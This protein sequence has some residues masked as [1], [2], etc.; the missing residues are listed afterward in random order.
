MNTSRSLLRP[1]LIFSFIALFSNAN[2]SKWYVNSSTG[3]NTN[4]GK[5]ATATPPNIGPFKEVQWAI[6]MAL[7][8]DSIFVAA[9]NYAE[10]LNIDKSVSIFGNNAGK[11]GIST[12]SAESVL[13]PSMIDLTPGNSSVQNCVVYITMASVVLD[14]F[15]IDGNNPSLSSGNNV[16]GKD[17]DI[18]NG[19]G[20]AG[21]FNSIYIQNNIIQNLNQN[22]VVLSGSVN[23]PN[24]NC[25][26]RFNF[27]KN[28]GTNS[29]GVKL[30]HGFFSDVVSNR[31]QETDI[32]VYITDFKLT[33]NKTWT[34][35]NNLLMGD[36]IGLMVDNCRQN[37]PTLLIQNNNFTT[38][39]S[40]V[41]D[42]GVYMINNKLG[43]KFSSLNNKFSNSARGY[44]LDNTDV[45][46]MNFSKDSFSKVDYGVS[47]LN[48]SDRKRTDS[49]NFSQCDFTDCNAFGVDVFSDSNRAVVKLSSCNFL[50]CVGGVM[51]RG[52]CHLIPGAAVFNSITDYYIM[53]DDG[54]ADIYSTDPIDATACIM[55]GST[56]TASTD[57]ENFINEDKIRHFLDEQRYPFVLFK[58]KYLYITNNDGNIFVQ[59][60][61]SK[62]S[63]DWHI[64]IDSVDHQQDVYIFNQT[65]FHTRGKV[66]IGSINMQAA[67]KSLFLHGP[68][69]MSNTLSLKAGFL[70]TTNGVATVGQPNIAKPL[71]DVS[72]GSPLSYVEGP[73]RIVMDGTS[74]DSAFFPV[75]KSGDFRPLAIMT[76]VSS[77]KKIGTVEAELFQGAAPSQNPAQGITHTSLVHHWK[78]NNIDGIPF[79]LVRFAGTY[80]TV[81]NDDEVSSPTQLK[82]VVAE[83]GSWNSIG[84]S[85]NAPSTGYIISTGPNQSMSYVSL[86]NA[87]H[88]SNKLG[89]T[90]AIAAF[91]ISNPCYPAAVQFTDIST[92]TSGLIT[93]WFWDFGDLSSM[94][95]TTSQPNPSYNYPGPGDY[96]V[97][98]KVWDNQGNQDSAERN[99]H[100]SSPPK[101][102]FIALVKCFPASV[103]FT[104]TSLTDATDPVVDWSWQVDV[105]NYSVNQF[106]H[107]FSSSGNHQVKLKVITKSGCSDTTVQQIY[108]GDTV[109]ISV[110]PAGPLSICDGDNV[111]LS[112]TSGIN[113]YSWNNGSKSQ[114][115]VVSQAGSYIVTGYN[116]NQCFARD[117]V[118]VSI[119][120]SPTADAGSDVT[121]E[122]G[123]SVQLTG[124]GGGSY[125]W[126]PSTGLSDATV[127]SPIASPTT[128]T[129]YIL[130]VYNALGCED[131]DTVLVVVEQVKEYLIPNLISPN[132]DGHNDVWDL[133]FLPGIDSAR[134]SVVSRWGREV[135]FSLHYNNDWSGTNQS[136]G[137][138]LPDGTY[139]FIIENPN[140]FGTLKGSL[141]II[142]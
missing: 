6:N 120:P 125:D 60:A 68:L 16:R 118:K 39:G 100:I 49:L 85:G 17:V 66:S 80:G 127:A 50:R 21:P 36:I 77:G 103:T 44:N 112:A 14:G 88:G 124:K 131:Y 97:K 128:T 134:V 109:K 108:Q 116:G 45:Q 27:I 132:G 65:H 2:A 117:T 89:K 73:L 1:F 129:E 23:T 37:T 13:M 15:T 84:G 67:G 79:T 8:G 48:F 22:G 32:A 53:F 76:S 102:G 123:Q 26:V 119:L 7:P 30:E 19:I 98:L 104:D 137:G 122:I 61:L 12:R 29:Y 111:T 91:D 107:S 133:S 81:V 87:G 35:N 41:S 94:K 51:M 9:G 114:S 78:T 130:R 95:D 25:A 31:I 38:L 24:S 5:S 126:M 56:G 52:N 71:M 11:A 69:Y 62:A 20:T 115:I 142:R 139:M 63:D 70:N 99:V 58:P 46:F 93:N 135:F 141:Q 106:T 82:L 113:S 90:G 59:Q 105:T 64:F 96:K 92:S 10:N 110:T 57:D 55:E 28:I 140:T 33:N 34:I 75:G 40:A 101:A 121:I 72:G 4:T 18:S 3:N 86:A 47:M 83:N 43:F 54:I 74:G 136:N 42:F 138:D